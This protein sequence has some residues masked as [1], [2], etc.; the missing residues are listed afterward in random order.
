VLFFYALHRTNGKVFKSLQFAL[1]FLAIKMGLIPLSL[2]FELNQDQPNQQLLSRVNKVES[3]G[4]HPYLSLYNDYRPSGLLMDSIERSSL[5][6]QYSYSQDAINELRAGDSRVREAGWVLITIWML[7]QQSVGFQPV[8]PV[9]RPPHVEAAQNLLFGKPKSDQL[10]CQQASMFDPQESEKSSL[11]SLEVL[12]QENALARITEEYGT[13]EYPKFDYIDGSLGLSAT[14]QQLAAKTYHAPSYKLYPELYGISQ[15]QMK[16]INDYGLVG[17]VQRGGELPSSNFIDAFHH[18][19]KT[20]YA[21]NKS[22]L[23]LN[24]SYR[25]ERAII[26]HNEIN[27][28]VLIFRADRKQLWTPSHLRPGQMKGY[29]ETGVIGKQGS[30]CPTGR[31]PPPKTT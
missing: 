11:Y 4:Y 21:R 28:E 25:G 16:A 13:L 12:S 18:H 26:V 24:G 8:R 27:G 23:N 14:H 2:P 15:A 19:I 6:P 7:Q 5:V 20:F 30:V 31:T 9:A 3:P 1:Y 29:L 22:N 10:F 17:Y